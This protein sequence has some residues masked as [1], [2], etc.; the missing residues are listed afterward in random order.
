[1]DVKFVEPMKNGL[2]VVFFFF[3]DCRL[4]GLSTIGR[5]I[6]ILVQGHRLYGQ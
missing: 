6:L 3:K 2:L 5:S 1:M 4:G